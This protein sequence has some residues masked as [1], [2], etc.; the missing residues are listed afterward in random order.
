MSIQARPHKLVV[1]ICPALICAT[2]I[3]SSRTEKN[4]RVNIKAASDTSV[5]GGFDSGLVVAG[6]GLRGLRLLAIL[7]APFVA[8]VATLSLPGSFISSFM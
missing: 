5:G 1:R 7:N 2:P 6:A 8:E 3:R 4:Q